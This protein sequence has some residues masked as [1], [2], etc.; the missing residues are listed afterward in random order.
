MIR[1]FYGN[2]R[3]K[4][5]KEAE[6]IF[7]GDFQTIDGENIKNTDAASI[8]LGGSLFSETQRILIRDLMTGNAEV[9][10]KLSE[11]T[12]TKNEVILLEEK[13]D[14]RSTAYKNLKDKVE[15]REFR[16]PE[17]NTRVI[18]DVFETAKRD[19]AKAIKILDSIREEEEPFQFLGLMVTQAVRDFERRPGEREKRVLVELAKVDM[20]MKSSGVQPWNLIDGFLLRVKTF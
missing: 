9:F 11:Y 14:K 13:I 17:K 8:F 1:V 10:G 18:F 19:G 3:V 12:G 20:Q 4:A 7:G 2:D 6:K 5:L 15:F 16:L